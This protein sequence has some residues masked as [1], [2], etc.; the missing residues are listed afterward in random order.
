[1]RYLFVFTFFPAF[2]FA[3]PAF[4]KDPDIVWAIEI[5]Q[6]WVVDA[7]VM[8]AEQDS[9][10]TTL[11]LLRTERNVSY[12]SSLNLADFVF[13][14]AVQE[15]LPIFKDAQ[16]QMPA[17]VVADVL[18]P[19]QDTIFTFNPETYETETKFVFSLRPS[20]DF[21]AWRLRQVLAYH[22]KSAT[23]ST[24][25]SAIAPLIRFKTEQSDSNA[26]QPVFWFRPDSKNQKL[27]SND[28]VW[29]KKIENKQAANQV[30]ITPENFV[31]VK[32]GFRNPLSHLLQVLK[33]DV[34]TPFYDIWNQQLLS[35][36]ARRDLMMKTDTVVDY[37]NDQGSEEPVKIVHREI[38]AADFKQLQF[39]QT[40]YWNERSNRLSIRLNAVAPLMDILDENGFFRFRKPLFYRR[41]KW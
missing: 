21:K 39:I 41:A 32:D 18:V 6:D 40:W 35:D 14:A 19:L 24:S 25:V 12:W 20:V 30:L 23:W 36:T 27:N 22:K 9:G 11:K 16:C 34:K 29:A 15:K 31:K 13:Q 10:I 8:E 26:L 7:H 2:L 3:Q 28:I 37:A 33:E 5:E 38:I 4:I 1:M 17:D